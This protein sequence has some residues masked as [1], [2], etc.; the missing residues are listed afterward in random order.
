MAPRR[1][2]PGYHCSKALKRLGLEAEAIA[3]A[4]R[5]QL[6]L[7]TG[8]IAE[9]LACPITPPD[10]TPIEPV[11]VVVVDVTE[12]ID[13]RDDHGDRGVSARP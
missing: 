3:L 1:H 8:E 6:A 7:D 13:A 11:P 4:L 2:P 12:A 5:R 10:G 9:V